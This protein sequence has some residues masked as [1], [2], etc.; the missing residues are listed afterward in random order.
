MMLVI[1]IAL[2]AAAAAA[3]GSP[4]GEQ[5]FLTVHGRAI[6]VYEDT[7][8]HSRTVPLLLASRAPDELATSWLVTSQGRQRHFHVATNGS[9]GALVLGPAPDNRR[10]RGGA[11]RARRPRL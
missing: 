7:K 1:S 11:E 4:A 8:A 10:Y 5:R 9:G 6:L 2:A 3:A